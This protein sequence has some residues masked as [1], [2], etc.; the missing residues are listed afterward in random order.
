MGMRFAYADPPYLGCGRMYAAHH[1][2]ALL[3]DDPETHRKL[4]GR[5]SDEYP[6]G[7]AMSLHVPSLRVLLPMCPADV[8]V[9]AYCKT[10]APFKVGVNPA[11]AWEPVIWRGGRRYTRQDPTVR[12]WHASAVA[13]KRGLT[14]AKSRAFSRWVF[15][16]LNGQPGDVLDDVF[17]GT[18]GVGAAWAE[19]V[20]GKSPLP[21]LPLERAACP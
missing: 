21:A 7:W 15:A 17:P 19:W 9:G 3:W 6:D 2:D 11:Y 20:G 16:L 8:R 1:P 10:F 12:D 18:G 13:L 5:L 14:G 4:I